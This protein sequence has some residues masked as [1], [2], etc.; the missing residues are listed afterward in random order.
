MC[1]R[2]ICTTEGATAAARAII[3]DVMPPRRRSQVSAVRGAVRSDRD[4]G[5]GSDGV[6]GDFGFSTT[7]LP[8]L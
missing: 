4:L 6:I 3:N 5:N 1:S 7:F 2:T 8:L